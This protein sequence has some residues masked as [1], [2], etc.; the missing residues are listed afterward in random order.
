M[1]PGKRQSYSPSK[2]AKAVAA[3]KSAMSIRDAESEFGIPKSTICD[4]AAGDHSNANIGQPNELNEVEESM[5][6]EFVKLLADWGFP[7]T[8]ADLCHF[9]KAY[10][11]KKGSVSRR[12][13]DN[14]PTHRWVTT[15]LGRHKD[16]SL[17]KTNAIKRSRGAVSREEVYAFF[18]NFAKAAEDV[19]P[20]NM[21]NYDETCFRDDI[22]LSKCLSRKGVKYVETVINT[23]KQTI[24]VMFCGSAAGKM[25][26]PMVVYKAKHMYDAWK[27]YGPKD[28]EYGSSESGWFN[29]PTFEKW[30]FDVALPILRKLDGKKLL[31]G[32]NLASHLS[33]SV[34][35]ACKNHNIQFVCLPANSTDKLQPLDVGVFGPLKAHWTSVLKDYKKKNPKVAGID[36][37]DFPAL[38]KKVLDLAKPGNNLPAAFGKCGIFPI[39]KDKAVQRIPHRRME[40]DSELTKELL[41]STL[42]EKLEEMRGFGKT[43][44]RKSR[45]KKVPAGKSHTEEEE[46][47]EE[48]TE[49][50]ELDVDSLLEEDDEDE[51]PRSGLQKKARQIVSSDEEEEEELPELDQAGGEAGAGPSSGNTAIYPVGSWVVAVY[52]AESLAEWYV[53]Q[54]EG[55]EP[56]EEEEGYTLLNYMERCGFNQFRWGKKKDVL[57]T[58]DRD[59]LLKIDPPIPVSSRYMGLPK[60]LVDKVYHHF[61]VQWL[62]ICWNLYFFSIFSFQKQVLK[63]IARIGI[64]GLI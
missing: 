27:R 29:S 21:F 42:G 48:E 64:F 36:K 12:F 52:K 23:S 31:L 58:R 51:T 2:L 35:K 7:F 49:D 6:K 9:V 28:A 33:P 37:S 15:F 11:D 1:A 61:R 38:L 44:V 39:S 45:G 14:L 13:T 47:A 60:H 10:L 41:T 22:R 4:N 30:F 40:V 32:D 50:E 16:L 57:K 8:S 63:V 26:P 59:I 53:A 34:I 19:P 20:E 5:L 54:V 56:E 24:S 55:E 17:R 43:P 3:V 25:M 18:D 46:E 62:F